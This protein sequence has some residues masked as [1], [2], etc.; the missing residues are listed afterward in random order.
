[1]Y[2]NLMNASAFAVPFMEV[3]GDV[4]MA[5]MLLWRAQVAAEALE[6]GAKDKDAAFYEGQ[7]QGADY[8]TAVVLPRTLGRM[9]AILGGCDVVNAMDDDAFGGR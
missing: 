3:C 7:I 9:E 8:F 5:W 2:G 1:M 4:V 6:A